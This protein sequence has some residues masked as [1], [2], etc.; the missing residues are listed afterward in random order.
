[1][2]QPRGVFPHWD[3]CFRMGCIGEV[4]KGSSAVGFIPIIQHRVNLI[5]C[6]QYG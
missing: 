4:A 2:H 1:M 3:D 6:L 5:G